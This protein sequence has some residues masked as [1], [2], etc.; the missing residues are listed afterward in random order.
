[1]LAGSQSLGVEAT[2]HRLPI[3]VNTKLGGTLA[4]CVGD[5]QRFV[6]AGIGCFGILKHGTGW[7]GH[8]RKFGS[9]ELVPYRYSGVAT[10]CPVADREPDIGQ[11]VG[12]GVRGPQAGDWVVIQ[13]PFGRLP[14]SFH[15]NHPGRA[16]NPEVW[17]ET[18]VLKAFLP[19][20]HRGK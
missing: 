4:G 6:R 16:W 3:P 14:W 8:R 17:L 5:Y 18:H 2:H 7:M 20:Y 12:I 1:M 9:P 10:D 19:D 11:A 15:T 13:V